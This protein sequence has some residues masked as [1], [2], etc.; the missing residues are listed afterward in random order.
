[1]IQSKSHSRQVERWVEQELKDRS[2]EDVIDA[3][4]K[5][6]QRVWNRAELTLGRVTMQAIADRIVHV[7]PGDYPWLAPVVHRDDGIDVSGLLHNTDHIS[8]DELRKG[9]GFLLA[10]FLRVLGHLTAEIISPKLHAALFDPSSP[11]VKGGK[12]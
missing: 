7:C 1:M 11:S 6:L 2:H 10:E 5:A 3:F 9:L 8:D 4:N 12:T